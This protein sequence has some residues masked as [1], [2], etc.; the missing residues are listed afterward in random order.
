MRRCAELE[1]RIERAELLL[2]NLFG[3]TGDLK[4][5]FHY[6]HI[7]IP[8]RTGGKL[9]AVYH[10]IVLICQDIQ[11][12]LGIQRLKSALGHGEWIMGKSDLLGFR[13]DLEHREI[14]HEAEAVCI[15]LVQVQ[16][17]TQL[18]ADLAG[19]VVGQSLHI[20][21]KEDGV[22]D[23]KVCQ[24]PQLL[25]LFLG[26]KLVDGTLIAAVLQ[27]LK[28]AQSAHA[29]ALGKFQH[30]FMLTLG[31][32]LRYI[33]TADSLS[34][35][36]L[37]GAGLEEFREID[38]PQRISEIR[39]ICTELQHGILVTDDGV[40]CLCNKASL[41]R[42]LPEDI[43]QHLFAHPENILLSSKAHLEIQLIELSRGTIRPG[44][45]ITKAG[46]N[47]EIL[48][49]AGN[50]QQLLILLGCLG[51]CIK[52]ALIPARWHNIVSCALRRRRAE[53]GRLNL[54]KAHILHL[55]ADIRNHL[56][57]EQDVILYL[58]IPKVQEAVLQPDILPDLAGG[59]DLEWKLTVH[60]A[61]DIDGMSL[62][63][64]GSRGDPGVVGFF[65]PVLHHA[66]YGNGLFLYDAVQQCCIP[67]DNLHN[68]V[69]I[70]EIHKGYASVIPDILYPARQTDM[71]SYVRLT[72]LVHCLVTIDVLRFHFSFL[73]FLFFLF[74][75]F[76]IVYHLICFSCLLSS[77]LLSSFLLSTFSIILS[78]LFF[79]FCLFSSCA[80]FIFLFL[81][82]PFCTFHSSA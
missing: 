77:F 53:N 47:L 69:H 60:P 67:E 6:F 7:M 70:P 68:A 30:L 42:K 24:A 2:Q 25:L 54:H 71:L 26:D 32:L 46:S 41:R 35:E 81:F 31:E 27:H 20:R 52:L 56:G 10:N 13:I 82:I 76:L 17:H 59:H 65:V 3:I 66:L 5:L 63:L 48:I 44:V 33:D 64:D 16:S 4:G 12:I 51:Q 18:V 14:V 49:K 15:L 43:R 80:L 36:G 79:T 39:L 19:I 29:D 22:A 38:D 1:R 74:L 21:D 28:I 40:G 61:Q 72:H 62:Q 23:R 9:N 45:L 75:L 55:S 58:F 50:H 73:V 57:T 78:V 37:K 34:M 11:R 8:D